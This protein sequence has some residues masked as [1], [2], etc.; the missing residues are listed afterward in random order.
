MYCNTIKCDTLWDFIQIVCRN[1]IAT[2]GISH[3]LSLQMC[4]GGFTPFQNDIFLEINY[5]QKFQTSLEKNLIFNFTKN[6]A[7]FHDFF[8]KIEIT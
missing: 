6:G 7:D 8:I 5:P 4:R 2:I 1:L 3:K